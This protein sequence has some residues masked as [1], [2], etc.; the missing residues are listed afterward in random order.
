[1]SAQNLVLEFGSRRDLPMRIAVANSASELV[2]ALGAVLG[3]LLVVALS[4]QAVFWIALAFQAAAVSIVLLFVDDPR[5][6]RQ[7]S[8]RER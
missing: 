8:P 3:G 6:R 4:Y 2:A 1:M 5:R 7:D